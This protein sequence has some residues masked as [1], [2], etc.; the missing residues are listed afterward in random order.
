MAIVSHYSDIGNLFHIFAKEILAICDV[1][2]KKTVVLKNYKDDGVNRWRLALLKSL[3]KNVVV[4]D[5]KGGKTDVDILRGK[6]NKWMFEPFEFKHIPLSPKLVEM[7]N[8]VKKF[9]NTYGVSPALVA[10]VY[11]E[12][13]RRLFDYKTGRLAHLVLS[14]KLGA[15]GIP[16]K[17]A[18][19]DNATFAEQARFLMDAKVLVAAHGAALTN[20]FLLPKH[21]VVVEVSFRRYW[22]CDPVCAGHVSGD[23]AYKT[24][25]FCRKTKTLYYHKADYHNMAQLF[26][27]EYQEVLLENADGYFKAPGDTV[28][29]PINLTNLFVDTDAMARLI[30]SLC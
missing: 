18:S 10:F 8:T 21:A 30:K 20:L 26:G 12:N 4:G 23:C 15:H 19:L 25:C 16:F 1:A 14:E 13:S 6:Y 28:Y 22:F 27:V 29:N 9:Q 17:A 7:A 11:R 24:D 2:G 3:F 5:Y